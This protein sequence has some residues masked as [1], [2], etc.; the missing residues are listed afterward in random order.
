MMDAEFSQDG[1]TLVVVVGR[2]ARDGDGWVPAG[3]RAYVW[4][5]ASTAQPVA[6][7]DLSRWTKGGVGFRCAFA[8]RP[9]ALHRHPDRPSPRPGV[10]G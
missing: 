9:A 2:L 10:G 6:V 7:V 4:S 8:R 3:T 5:L 1:S